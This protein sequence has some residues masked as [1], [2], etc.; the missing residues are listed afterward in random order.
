MVN[1]HPHYSRDQ[2]IAVVHNGIIE[3]YQEL[4]TR[5]IQQ[6]LLCIPDGYRGSG[7]TAGLLLHRR[8]SGG[9]PGCHHPHDDACAWFLCAGH[10][11]CRPARRGIRSAERQPVDCRKAENGSLIASDVPA[12]LKYTRTVYYID[13]LESPA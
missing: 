9:Q 7:P 12:L 6:A 11:V 4:K 3:N 1:A 2:K 13:N 10:P 8:F 5:L